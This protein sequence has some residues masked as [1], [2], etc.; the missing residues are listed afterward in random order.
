MTKG[1]YTIPMTTTDEDLYTRACDIKSKSELKWED[2]LR[3]GVE[4]L[5]GKD[6]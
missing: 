2:V 3:A 5:E 1:R 4:A 6:E